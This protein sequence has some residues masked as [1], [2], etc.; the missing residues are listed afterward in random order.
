MTT[1]VGTDTAKNPVVVA[2]IALMGATA[3]SWYLGDGHGPA[4]L[5][6]VGVLVVAFVKVHLVGRYFMELKDAPRILYGVFAAWNI[7]VC[8][9]L[10]TLY[11]VGV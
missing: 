8:S 4:R 1:L 6:T 9:V 2:W 3:L 7:V 10:I 11:L 5:A